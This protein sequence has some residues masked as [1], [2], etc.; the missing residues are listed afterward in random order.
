V[1]V[2]AAYD[3]FD[4]FQGFFTRRKKKDNGAESTAASPA[5]EAPHR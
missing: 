5:G 3:L 1:V 4:D 2:P